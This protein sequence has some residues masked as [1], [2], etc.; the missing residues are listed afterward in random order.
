MA[1]PQRSLFIINF[2]TGISD[3]L[4]L[5]WAACFIAFAAFKDEERW[6]VT[7]IGIAVSIIGALAFGLARFYGE[8]EEIHHR[9]PQL[10]ATEAEKEAAMMRAI[11]IDPE[12]SRS[13]LAQMEEEKELWLREIRENHMD[14]ENY[15]P[16]RA[17]K[18][19]L[20]TAVGFLAAGLLVCIAFSLLVIRMHQ[21]LI[22]MLAGPGICFFLGC[23]KGLLLGRNVLRN[24]LLH[25]ITAVLVIGV[26][27]LVAAFVYWS[28]SGGIKAMMF[29]PAP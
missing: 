3:G 15:D 7:A 25:F 18:S 23:Y 28:E 5:P 12:L 10:A 27:L 22:A 2:I 21:P 11:D 24:G 29:D 19:G 16:K 26:A 13:M 4:I 8:K 9:H 17:G 14:W 6:K 20:Q 1:V